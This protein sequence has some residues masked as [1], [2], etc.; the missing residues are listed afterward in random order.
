L[1]EP[2]AVADALL[3]VLDCVQTPGCQ[4]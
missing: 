3:Q 2:R 1:E 4:G